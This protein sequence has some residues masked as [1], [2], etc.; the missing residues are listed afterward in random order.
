MTKGLTYGAVLNHGRGSARRPRWVEW[1]LFG[2][3]PECVPKAMLR[4]FSVQSSVHSSLMI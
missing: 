1:M 2:A 3:E 4:S